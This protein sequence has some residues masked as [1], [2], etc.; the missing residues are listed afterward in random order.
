M[1]ATVERR[2]V[3]EV[4]GVEHFIR[5]LAVLEP[6]YVE[7]GGDMTRMMRVDGSSWIDPRPVPVVL[8]GI[9]RYYGVDLTAVR[10][11]YGDILGKRLHVPLPFSTHLVLVPLKMRTPR[12][13]KDGTTGYVAAHVITGIAEG[14][15]P[16]ACRLDLS[17]GRTL[18]CLQSADFAHQQLRHARIVQTFYVERMR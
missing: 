10:E 7:G 13:A 3:P 6:V 11:R 15:S 12:V 14:H 17:E 4:V 9:A 5:D 2:D 16:T 18:T 1:V 8:K